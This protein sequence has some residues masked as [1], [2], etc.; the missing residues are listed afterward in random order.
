VLKQDPGSRPALL[1]L[2]RIAR[3]EYR[4]DDARMIY[5]QLLRTHPNDL[6]ATNGLAWVALANRRREQGRAG[7]EHVL[8][9]DPNN[10]EARIGLTKVDDVYRNVVEATGTLVSTSQGTSWGF[11]GR[12]LFGITALDTVELGST[13]YT[14]E[15]QTLTAVGVAV[16]PSD[17]ITLGYHRLVPLRYAV[18]LT[19][20]YRAH[21]GLPTEHWFDGGVN[22]YLTD[23]LQWFGGYR[24]MFGAFQWDGRVLRTGL[25][26]SLSD[27]WQVTA[28]VFDAAQA[29]YKNYQPIVSGVFDVTYYGPRNMLVVAGAGYSPAISNLDLHVR[30]ILPVTDRVAVQIVVAHNSVNA[31]TRASVG[32]RVNW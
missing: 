2:A 12:G 17:D 25:A 16:L 14:R 30:T 3:G 8:T 6:D 15:L 19:Y 7:F 26:I 21:S 27:S 11:G 24:Q 23:Y 22:F 5:E 20:D 13:H 32:L 1:G 4:L 28:T 10:S 18:S 31:D 29:I 9:L